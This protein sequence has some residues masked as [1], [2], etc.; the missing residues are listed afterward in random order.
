MPGSGMIYRPAQHM[1]NIGLSLKP[2]MDEALG[3]LPSI[4]DIP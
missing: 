3:V 2:S 1:Q 4:H